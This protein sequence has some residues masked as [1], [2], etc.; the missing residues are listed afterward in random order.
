GGRVVDRGGARDQLAVGVAEPVALRVGLRH[1]ARN[2]DAVTVDHD[3]HQLLKSVAGLLL[4]ADEYV[5]LVAGEERL[6]L[7]T[8][9]QLFG[10]DGHGN[11]GHGQLTRAERVRCRRASVMT[12]VRVSHPCHDWHGSPGHP[13]GFFSRSAAK[14]ASTLASGTGATYPS[15]QIE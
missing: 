9:R 1:G 7:A 8:Q 14:Y 10:N 13:L 4:A 11:I 5:V 6:L 3:G 15:P 12:R 2:L